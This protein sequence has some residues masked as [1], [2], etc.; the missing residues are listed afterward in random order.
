MIQQPESSRLLK[1]QTNSALCWIMWRIAS[2]DRFPH[3]TV[4]PQGG[5]VVHF[6]QMTTVM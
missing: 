6:K 4:A 5:T 1:V 3:I 2:V